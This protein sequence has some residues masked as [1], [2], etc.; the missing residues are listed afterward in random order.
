M[1]KAIVSLILIFVIR[2]IFNDEKKNK[3]LDDEF[4]YLTDKPNKGRK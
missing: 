2:P 3:E 4:K 1:I